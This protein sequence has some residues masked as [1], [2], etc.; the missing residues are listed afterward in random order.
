MKGFKKD[1]TP[2]VIPG[3]NP[4]QTTKFC[5]SGNPETGT[6]WNEGLPGNPSGSIYNCGG[7]LTGEYHP[8]NPVGDK[9]FLMSWGSGNNRVNPGDTKNIIIAQII[10]RGTN[11]L[12]SVT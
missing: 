2:W 6:G 8:V 5:Y 10:A 9:R 12:N 11:N 4:P 3:T 7:S 1:S